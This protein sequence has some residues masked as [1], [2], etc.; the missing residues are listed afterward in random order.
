M[1]D[2]LKNHLTADIELIAGSGGVFEVEVDGRQVFSKRKT[3]RFPTLDEII[4]L[5]NN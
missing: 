3:G 4:L 1:G 5:I 2:D